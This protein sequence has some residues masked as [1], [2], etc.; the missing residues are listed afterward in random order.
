VRASRLISAVDAHAGGAV[1]RVV[2]GGVL[3]IPGK[4]ML[5]KMVY[6]SK[7]LESLRKFL[8]KEPRGHRAMFA[9][10][11]T[12]PTVEEADVGVLYL[13]QGEWDSMCGH[14]TVGTCTVLVEM[15]LVTVKEPETE[16]VLD[17]PAGIVRARVAVK[18]GSAEAV[19]FENVPAFLFKSDV[20][21]N[22][23][24]I[25]P[26]TVDIAYGGVFYSILP[27]ESVGLVTEPGKADDII[28]CAQKIR[29][30]VNE[31]VEI[32][33]PLQPDISGAWLVLFSSEADN[34]E[35]SMKGT[36]VF[37]PGEVDRSACGTGTCARMAQLYAKGQLHLD[38]DFVHESIMGSL[39][40]GRLIRESRVGPYPAVVP[41]I[42]GRGF[43]TAI[44]QFVLD[45]GDPFPAGFYL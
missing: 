31:Q 27:A 16:V 22:V 41:T 42:S 19:T 34:P 5:D 10:I 40:T 13:G 35:A 21:V 12:E 9:A 1:E 44:H 25:G 4:T 30:A 20:E 37:S 2:V 15:G 36:V 33:H 11:L 6:G 24:T 45:P 28:S 43:V 32:R 39:F 23:P 38:E 3:P 8:V 17:T 29:D 26:V 14:G 18:D 7:N